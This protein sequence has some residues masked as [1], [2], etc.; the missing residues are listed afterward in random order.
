LVTE[1]DTVNSASDA[2]ADHAADAN[3]DTADA[4][5]LLN[6]DDVAS[7]YWIKQQPLPYP[8]V[9]TKVPVYKYWCQEWGDGQGVVM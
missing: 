5:E 4:L 7:V 3:G 6:P 8:T 9:S 2:G 1:E